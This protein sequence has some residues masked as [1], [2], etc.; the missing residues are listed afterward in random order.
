MTK[1]EKKP[2]VNWQIT[3]PFLLV[4]TMQ[5][6]TIIWMASSMAA[7]IDHEM[8]RLNEKINESREK[9]KKNSDLI[10]SQAK[11]ANKISIDTATLRVQ[12]QHIQKQ[13]SKIEDMIKALLIEARK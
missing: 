8:T 12:S 10:E 4:F 5:V 9:I 1:A 11:L 7:N 13:V 2:L 6:F 3:M